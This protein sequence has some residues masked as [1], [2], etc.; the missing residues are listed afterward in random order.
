MKQFQHIWLV[1]L[2]FFIVWVVSCKS[3]E[4]SAFERQRAKEWRKYNHEQKQRKKENEKKYKRHFK[5][6]SKPMR[7]L[8]KKDV[9]RMNRDKRR[10]SRQYG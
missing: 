2:S 10:K 4:N 1:L 6:Q 9:R 7:K 3:G 5:N 8:M